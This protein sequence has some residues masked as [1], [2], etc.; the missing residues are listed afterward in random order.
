MSDRFALTPSQIPEGHYI[1]ATCQ[2]PGCGG[3]R[4]VTRALML[5]KAGD[6]PLNLI[7]RRVRCVERPRAN[8]R[9]PACGGPMEFEW[10][11]GP[12]EK[13]QTVG[14]YPVLTKPE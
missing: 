10:G 14:R 12:A 6:I 8:K 3:R 2:R 13:V 1:V 4:Y 9:G 7:E 11:R 5:E